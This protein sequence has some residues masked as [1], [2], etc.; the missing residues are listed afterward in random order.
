MPSATHWPPACRW[1]TVLVISPPAYAMSTG[2]FV[3]RLE[4]AV[5]RSCTVH[6]PAVGSVGRNRSRLT[7]CRRVSTGHGR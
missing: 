7:P 2:T 3:A 5:Q 4:C 1:S 6:D